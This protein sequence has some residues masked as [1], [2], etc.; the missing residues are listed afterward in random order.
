MSTQDT[1]TF[2]NELDDRDLDEKG[3]ERFSRRNPK[4]L[5]KSEQVFLHKQ[6]DSTAS[7]KYTYKAARFEAWWLLDSLGDFYEHKW[8]SDVLSRVKGGKEASV[9]L[10]R[11]GDAIPGGGLVAAKVYRPRM[12]RNLKNDAI[13]RE[14]RGDLNDE[15]NTLF[16][17]ADV[18]AMEK[19]TSYGEELRHTSWIAHEFTTLQ[20]LHASGADV[21][22]AYAM[23]KNAIL[24][25]YI[26]DVGMCA[27]ALSEISLERD[28]TRPL[29][30]RVIRNIDIML[31]ANRIHGDLSAYNILYWDGDITLIDF[32]QVVSPDGNRNAFR[33]FERD[34]IR[35]CEY[36]AKQGV[37]VNPRKLAADLWARHG[38]KARQ[39]VDVRLLDAE[40]PLDRAIW[41]KQKSGR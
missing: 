3:R 31:G 24:M 4:K 9:Y 6:D 30:D 7:F 15:G 32:P 8:I 41:Q 22:E 18:H 36:F 37:H 13:Y 29:F 40:D 39:E 25:G 27:P 21:P 23:A 38:H 12:L 16:K 26:G 19:R 20:T 17:D 28:E 10:C 34:V 33:I 2:Y 5:P 35:V 14:G 11:A 1:Y